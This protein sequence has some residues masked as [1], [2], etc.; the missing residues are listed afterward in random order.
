MVDRIESD[1]RIG[2]INLKTS[3]SRSKEVRNLLKLAENINSAVE[4][5]P[6]GAS[7]QEIQCKSLE[8]ALK[9]KLE[10][11]EILSRLS[12]IR[13]DVPVPFGAKLRENIVSLEKSPYE[14]KLSGTGTTA[15]VS[16][17]TTWPPDTDT[18]PPDSD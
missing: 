5:L 16:A 3:S 15:T 2:G 7:S 11:D 12:E 17:T 14:N 4:F 1:A 9:A 13:I 6:C 8:V 18:D 10:L